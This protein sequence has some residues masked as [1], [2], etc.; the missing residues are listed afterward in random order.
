MKQLVRGRTLGVLL[1]GGS[2]QVAAQLLEQGF[3][4]DRAIEV[5]DVAK[6]FAE[7]EAE[8][9]SRKLTPRNAWQGCAV[10][11]R[12]VDRKRESCWLMLSYEDVQGWCLDAVLVD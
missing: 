9:L 11:R 10:V 4:Q 12:Y 8:Y 2:S 7:D 5:A 3:E 1:R 6:M